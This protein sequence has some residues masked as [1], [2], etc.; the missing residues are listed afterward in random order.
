VLPVAGAQQQPPVV[1]DGGGPV[2]GG[3]VLP[4]AAH[5]GHKGHGVAV[6]GV[7]GVHRHRAG[8]PVHR[9]QVGEA[10]LRVQGHAIGGELLF[11]LFHQRLARLVP[12]SGVGDFRR[13]LG[14]VGGSRCHRQHDLRRGGGGGS[15]GS[16]GRRRGRGRRF[17]RGLFA[18][19]GQQRQRQGQ[20]K[21]GTGE[22]H[23]DH[24]LFR[25]KIRKRGSGRQGIC[26]PRKTARRG[27][28]PALRPDGNLRF[29]IF[30]RKF[31]GF[32]GR[33]S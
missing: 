19:P 14:G 18:A 30:V 6:C 20:G 25:Y 2:A 13:V 10:L 11:Q 17:G 9:Q 16:R 32:V 5:H 33:A 28:A 21:E 7:G 24:L 1:V 8:R 3:G 31:R 29:T 15:G 26:G 4:A 23:K 22:A 27:Q 12:G